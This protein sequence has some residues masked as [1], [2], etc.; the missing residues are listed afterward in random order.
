M[1]GGSAQETFETL[2]KALESGEGERAKSL[3]AD[4]FVLVGYSQSN[5]PSAPLKVEG[6]RNVERGLREVFERETERQRAGYPAPSWPTMPEVES[7][8]I[9][10]E[11]IGDNR[12]SYIEECGLAGGGRVVAA[13]TCEVQDGVIVRETVVETWDEE[14]ART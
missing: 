11:V 12:F 8:T 4:D 2:R 14:V 10:N 7:R 3:Y 13:V 1:K 5:P 9:G 6:A